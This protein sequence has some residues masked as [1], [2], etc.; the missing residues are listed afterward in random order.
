MLINEIINSL[1]IEQL[2]NTNNNEIANISNIEDYSDNSNN[3]I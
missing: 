2:S 1:L 3:Q